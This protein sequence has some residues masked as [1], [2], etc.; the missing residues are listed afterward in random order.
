[1]EDLVE[2]LAGGNVT[3]VKVVLASVVAALAAYQ[4]F[5]MA[6]GYGKLRLPFLGAKPASFT[7]RAV[8]DTIVVITIAVA[9]MC[10][11]Y[12]G[13]EDGDSGEETR[14]AVHVAAGTL[15]LAV[16]ALKT[17]RNVSRTKR[18]AGKNPQ[19][20]REHRIRSSLASL[21]SAHGRFG[22]PY[23]LHPRPATVAAQ[24]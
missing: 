2:T 5:L 24:A 8:G 20:L 15:L 18:S 17:G 10:L 11:A 7:H 23:D 13:F 6:V 1:M 19:R 21:G 9:F 22:R 16:L 4:V 3:E 12:F 14:T